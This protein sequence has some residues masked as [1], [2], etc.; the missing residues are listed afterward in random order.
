[1]AAGSFRGTGFAHPVR[2][3]GSGRIV[4]ASERDL[5]DRSIVLILGTAKGERIMRP[6]FGS[7]LPDFVFK[8]LSPVNLQRM[9][10]AVKAALAT[11]EPR[12]RVRRVEARQSPQ[13]LTTALI[14]IDYEVRRSHTK[15]NLVYPF[16]AQ[17]SPQ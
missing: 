5:L 8:P 14:S 11:W 16:Y 4:A 3:D 6:D 17:G 15:R 2:V 1:V 13:D 9:A 7:D 10:T 12:I